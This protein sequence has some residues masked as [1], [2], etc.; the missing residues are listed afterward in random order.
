MIR[1]LFHTVLLR[2]T[3]LLLLFLLLSSCASLPLAGGKEPRTIIIRNRSGADIA[4]V[5]LR[6]AGSGSRVSRFGTLAP[7]PMGV[8]QEF[9]RPTDPPPLPRTVAVEWVDSGGKPH[10]RELS[11]VKALRNATGNRDEALVFEIGP[12]EAV[13]V[14]IEKIPE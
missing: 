8:P 9:G 7:V 2:M 14:F 6:E 10:V 12:Y 4:E 11:I 1:S 13:L 5:S 3:A